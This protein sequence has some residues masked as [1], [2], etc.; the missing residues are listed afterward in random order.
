M[1]RPHSLTEVASLAHSRSELGYAVAEFLDQFKIEEEGAMLED[2]PPLLRSQ[3]QDEGVADAY[4]AAVA[5][6]LSRSSNAIPPRWT[7]EPAR[8]LHRPWFA[9]PGPS[10]RA[11]LLLESPAAFHERNLFVSANALD[12]A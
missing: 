9:S 7:W 12:R 2:E 6:H 1:K 11:T 3:L 5:V 4:L 10:L 8:Y